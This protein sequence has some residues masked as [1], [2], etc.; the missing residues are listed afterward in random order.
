V[1]NNTF[2]FTVSLPLPIVCSLPFPRPFLTALRVILT[3]AIFIVIA[4]AR[5]VLSTA[6]HSR[7]R[8]VVIIIILV[9]YLIP[10]LWSNGQEVTWLLLPAAW[11]LNLCPE[12]ITTGPS[13]TL[14]RAFHPSR[15]C[16]LRIGAINFIPDGT[17]VVPPPI[18]HLIMG[19]VKHLPHI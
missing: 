4:I 15:A 12:I 9:N 18:V 2:L 14:A 3:L 6:R 17:G 19:F 11:R 13:E 16:C 10:I 1:F 7:I 5:T 8:Q